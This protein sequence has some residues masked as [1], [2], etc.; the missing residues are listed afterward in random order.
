MFNQNMRINSKNFELQDTFE[1]E[2]LQLQNITD[3]IVE[4]ASVEGSEE[5]PENI[6]QEND[7]ESYGTVMQEDIWV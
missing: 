7:A 5:N 6:G 1:I 2:G 4:E 3:T